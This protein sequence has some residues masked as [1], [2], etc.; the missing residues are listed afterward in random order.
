[1]NHNGLAWLLLRALNVNADYLDRLLQPLGGQLPQNDQQMS[2]LLDRIRRQGHLFEGGFRHGQQQAGTGDPG[3]Y[4]YFPT[5]GTPNVNDFG[6][7]GGG[8]WHS[9]AHVDATS[10]ACAG[11]NP[12]YVAGAA[13]E[14]MSRMMGSAFVSNHS[15]EG[16]C[17]TCGSFF[18]DEEFSSATETDDGSHDEGA[19]SYNTVNLGGQVRSDED[20]RGNVLLQEYLQARRRWRRWTGKPPRRYRRANF[21]S[22]DA[23]AGRLSRGPYARTYAAFLPQSAFAGGKSKGK[24]KSGGRGPR[25]NP[26]GKDGQ[27]LKCAKCGSTE[28]LWRR[29]PQV[30]SSGSSGFPSAG[31]AHVTYQAPAPG[32]ANLAMM[33]TAGQSPAETWNLGTS[34]ALSG[35][36]FHYLSGPPSNAPSSAAGW[37]QTSRFGTAIEDEMARLESVS[38]VG[39]ERSRKS[40][41]SDPPSW[42]ADGSS[43]ADR[44]LEA[45]PDRQVEALRADVNE[46]RFP[47]PLRLG[48]SVEELG[49]ASFTSHTG[50]GTGKEGDRQR[51]VVQLSSLLCAWW[52]TDEQGDAG[53]V[54][55]TLPADV[56]SSGATYHMKTRLE[57][58]RPGLLVDPGAHDNLVGSETVKRM[59]EVT[60]LPDRL[61]RMTKKLNVEGVGSGSQAAE[62]A[63]QVPLKLRTVEGQAL[64]GT[65]TA[66]VIEGSCLPPLLGLRSLRKFNAV[67]DIGQQRLYI[68]GPAGCEVKC[69]AGTQVFD[70]T[71]SPSGHLILP[72]DHVEAVATPNANARAGESRSMSPSH[73]RQSG[74]RLDFSMSCRDKADAT[75]SA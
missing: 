63:K 28:H 75:D 52:E 7:C 5:F 67:L 61:L 1:M 74:D 73:Q 20:A 6:A 53:S 66:P 46:P 45:V 50:K 58:D 54:E 44:N 70:L 57:G 72:M 33:T 9:G 38:Q 42:H 22:R 16:Q 3:N 14:G 56:I 13:D 51:A 23:V 15:S 32:G 35:V 40:R 2:Q 10:S 8:S 71:M 4:H 24:G 65:Y 49:Q 25:Q 30:V 55:A 34:G 12:S 17:M 31:N 18:E 37:Q 36:A 47:P 69:C 27:L 19:S 68:P 11:V 41:R 64:P 39:S 26:R 43:E 21:R 60:G 59:G 48:P 62:Y 29:C